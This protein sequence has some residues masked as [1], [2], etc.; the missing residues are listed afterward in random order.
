MFHAIIS[1]IETC[2][3][4][5]SQHYNTVN[6]KHQEEMKKIQKQYDCQQSRRIVFTCIVNSK[7]NSLNT[8]FNDMICRFHNQYRA[9]LENTEKEIMFTWN[10]S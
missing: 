6:R 5:F 4:H 9:S 2:Y 7:R 1:K 3:S 10:F 8:D